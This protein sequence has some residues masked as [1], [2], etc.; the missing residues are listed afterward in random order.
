M[1]IGSYI[2]GFS[3]RSLFL[4]VVGLQAVQEL[5][6]RLRQQVMAGVSLLNFK[7]SPNLRIKSPPRIM[8]KDVGESEP[9]S[10]RNTGCS[11]AVPKLK[12]E[13]LPLHP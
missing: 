13:F 8:S 9:D 1:V 4:L 10:E 11:I 5:L 3:L 2:L 12:V 6:Q 7:S